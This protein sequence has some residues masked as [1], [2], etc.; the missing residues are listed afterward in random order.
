[1]WDQSESVI[2]WATGAEEQ[3]AGWPDDI[4]LP[5]GLDVGDFL[6]AAVATEPAR[7]R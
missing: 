1:M 5:V 4:R 6:R 2:R 3:V 7:N